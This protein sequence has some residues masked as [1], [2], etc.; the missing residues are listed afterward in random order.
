MFNKLLNLFR[1]NRK[2]TPLEDFTTELFVGVLNNDYKLKKAFCNEFLGLKS[3]EYKISTQQRY[4]LEDD[5]NCII[6]VVI[7]G[8]NDICFIE[9]KV[10]SK[11]GYNQLERYSKVLDNELKNHN[12]QTKLCYC[13]KK[14]DIKKIDKHSFYQFKWKN[15]SDFFRKNS[16]EK[17]TQLFIKYLKENDMST[18]MEIKTTDLI[19]LEKL[20]KVLNLV[21]KNINN[22][23]QEFKTR[24]GSSN[25]TECIKGKR[26]LDQLRGNER[27]C[28]VIDK[29]TKDEEGYSEILYGFETKGNL[30][31][32]IFISNVNKNHQNFVDFIEK[33]KEKYLF[34]KY[35]TGTRLYFEKNLGEFIN[36]ENSEEKIKKWFIESFNKIDDIMKETKNLISWKENT[37]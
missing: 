8:D 25:L 32:Q 33:N 23:L 9:N 7:E 19:G 29:I 5:P 26:L 27:I 35:D 10:D 37:A 28:V 14:D 20:Y 17:I 3:T 36:D 11:E 6:D 13:T 2:K 16:K 30:V 24:Y 4:D 22:V 1:K 15:V 34:E 12:K 21:E 18:D 31:S